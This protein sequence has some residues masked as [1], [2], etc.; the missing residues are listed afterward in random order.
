MWARTGG[1]GSAAGG[2]GAPTPQRKTDRIGEYEL[3]LRAPRAAGDILSE[4]RALLERAVEPNFFAGP[5]FLAAV[6]THLPAFRD[7]KV[8]LLWRGTVLE[9]AFPL[10]SAPVGFGSRDVHAP[11]LERGC[12]GAPL[13]DG[14]HADAVLAAACGWL[15]ARHAAIVFE[16][17]SADSPFRTVLEAFAQ[18]SG[19]SL[20]RRWN[21]AGADDLPAVITAPCQSV[22]DEV[23]TIDRALDPAA[24]RTAVE[25]YLMLEA[26]DALVAGRPALIQQPGEANL[27]RTVTRQLG[28]SRQCQIFTLRLE[29]RVAASAI[30]LIEPRRA[31]VWRIVCEPEMRDCPVAALLEERISRMLSRRGVIGAVTGR[32]SSGGLIATCRLGLKPGDRPDSIARRLGERM[33]RSADRFTTAA[34]SSLRSIRRKPAA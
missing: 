18:R 21:Q 16:G 27:V 28:R 23:A 14:R 1:Y 26:Q 33:L 22:E 29:G 12:S 19:R 3:E 5:D 15:A 32:S 25:D 13:V 2:G 7:L 9:G 24:I 31:R 17:L 10:A 20:V 6:T 11:Q 8:L 34:Q 4:W 30:V